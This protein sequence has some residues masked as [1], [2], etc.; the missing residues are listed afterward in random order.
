MNLCS[1]LHT[2]NMNANMTIP[3]GPKFVLSTEPDFSFDHSYLISFFGYKFSITI[4]WD[5]QD[6]LA[7][8]LNKCFCLDIQEFLL[9]NQLQLGTYILCLKF[10]CGGESSHSSSS[11]HIKQHI[12]I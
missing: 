9:G 11:L 5:T 3:I 1:N 2:P 7:P 12:C 10:T 4:I 8:V 6:T